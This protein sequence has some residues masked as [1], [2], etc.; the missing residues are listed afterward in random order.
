MAEYDKRKLYP[1]DLKR[2]DEEA[3]APPESRT[4]QV[5]EQSIEEDDFTPGGLFDSPGG[6]IKSGGKKLVKMATSPKV[7]LK[8]VKIGNEL[9]ESL[10]HVD[11]QV[12]DKIRAGKDGLQKAVD[13]F[14]KKDIKKT[15]K[16]LAPDEVRVMNYGQKAQENASSLGGKFQNLTPMTKDVATYIEKIKKD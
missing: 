11:R 10:S 14:T 8:L 12:Y 13:F 15:A 16:A 1:A 9:R 2:M 3:L 6:L 7:D 4:P 5:Q